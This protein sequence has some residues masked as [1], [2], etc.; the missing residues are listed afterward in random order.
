M[1][2]KRFAVIIIVTHCGAALLHGAAHGALGVTAGGPGGLLVVAVA[3]Y[4]GPLV[5]LA[6]LLGG[7]GAAGA[8]VLSVS[9]AA[10]LGYGVMFHYVLHTADHVAYA[11]PGLWGDVFRST[12]AI[13]ALLEACG[14]AAGVRL[15]PLRIPALPPPAPR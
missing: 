5:A 8:I 6:A 13:I 2:W 3:V 12:A 9:M 15:T 4:V 10:A 7:R 1:T 14:L 11:P